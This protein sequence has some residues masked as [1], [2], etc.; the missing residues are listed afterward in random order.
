MVSAGLKD[1]SKELRESED[2]H[3]MVIHGYDNLVCR[4]EN[5]EITLGQYLG[6][7]LFQPTNAGRSL[8]MK[9]TR[10]LHP[11]ASE[12][13]AAVNMT[14]LT[15]NIKLPASQHTPPMT[16]PPQHTNG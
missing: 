15:P 7:Y 16:T 10:I 1:R 12:M 13:R 9:I 14:T 3:L 4:P 8:V 11:L 2:R 6:L 5:A